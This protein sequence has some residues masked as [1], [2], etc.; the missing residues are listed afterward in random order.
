MSACDGE[1]ITL[2]E[3]LFLYRLKAS[4]HYGYFELLPWTRKSR[5]IMGFPSS[6]HDWKSRYFFISRTGWETLSDDFWWEVP[7]LLQKWEVL[8]LGAYFHCPLLFFFHVL[9]ARLMTFSFWFFTTLDHP[10]LEDKHRHWVRVA[11]A[12]TR[13]IEDFD[14]L[15]DPRHLFDCCLGPEPSKYILEKICQEEK[16]KIIYPSLCLF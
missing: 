7:R 1:M 15:V 9:I 14:N 3:F 6:F 8:A 13:E 5:I 2:N 12:Y 10:D 16:S 4:T 11:L